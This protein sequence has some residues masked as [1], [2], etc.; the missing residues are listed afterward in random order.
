MVQ[1]E[2]QTMLYSGWVLWQ[3]KTRGTVSEQTL[4]TLP[5]FKCLLASLLT[6]ISPHQPSTHDE[7]LVTFALG[8]LN[9]GQIIGASPPPPHTHT[10]FLS[11]VSLTISSSPLSPPQPKNSSCPSLKLSRFFFSFA[12][13]G[14][15]YV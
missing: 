15:N 4:L 6:K 14:D 8:I 2:H 1:C 7:V 12:S 13:M 9:L 10:L 11:Y 3:H 5:S